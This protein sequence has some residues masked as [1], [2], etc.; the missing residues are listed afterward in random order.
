M[1]KGTKKE[2][3][4]VI[5]KESKGN[6]LKSD[7]GTKEN[8]TDN[9]TGKGQTLE[10]MKLFTEFIEQNDQGKETPTEN[11]RTDNLKD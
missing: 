11:K 3:Q 5:E 1:N 10:T 8:E 6:D 7:Y 4:S 2:T 9:T